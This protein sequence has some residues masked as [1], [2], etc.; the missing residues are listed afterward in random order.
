MENVGSPQ[1]TAP[2]DVVVPVVVPETRPPGGRSRSGSL[3]CLAVGLGVCLLISLVLNFALLGSG[4][5]L[6]QAD[7]SVKEKYHSLNRHGKEKIA[8]VEVSGTIMDGENTRK[9]IDA[10][11]KDKKVKAVVLRVDSPGGTINGSDY[12][13]HH[14][15]ELTKQRK[16]P[17]VVSMGG[18]AASGGYY[19][20]MAVGHTPDT[21]FAEPT[22]WTGSIGVIIPHYDLSGLLKEYKIQENSIKSHPLKSIGSFT[23][24]MTEEERQILQG[25]VDQGFQQF[26]DVVKY[27]RKQFSENDE[28]LK[29]VATGQVFTAHD[30]KEKGLID[31]IGYIEEA[32]DRAIELAA[33]DKDQAKA[34][35]YEPQVGLFEQL[36][37]GQTRSA[38]LDLASLLELT[39]PRA[40]YL[41]TSLPAWHALSR[42]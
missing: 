27:G 3:G 1:M 17:L 23:K 39:V 32:I 25:L 4:E 15:V 35:K 21:I 26:Q 11:K 34:V 16:I 10:V 7:S 29:A 5:S 33:V 2:N 8:I 41:C 24:P 40:Y 9:V 19:I 36:M 38:N 31:R 28:A 14:L 42:P 6:L 20:A 12:I 30:A 18:L 22:T 13:F 37:F